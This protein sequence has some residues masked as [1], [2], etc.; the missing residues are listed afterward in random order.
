MQEIRKGLETWRERRA[1]LLM[2][3][4]S[5]DKS[6]EYKE[7]A[8]R[9]FVAQSVMM[10][11]LSVRHVGV[12]NEKDFPPGG[13]VSAPNPESAEVEQGEHIVPRKFL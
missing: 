3:I 10:V 6:V 13:I 5:S 1:R 9:L 7:M 12:I 4:S 11:Q 2:A 8:G